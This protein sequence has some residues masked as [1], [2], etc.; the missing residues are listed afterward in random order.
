MET[1]QSIKTIVKAGSMSV[2]TKG[3]VKNSVLINPKLGIYQ[4]CTPTGELVTEGKN[5]KGKDKRPFFIFIQGKTLIQ[6][7]VGADFKDV[8]AFNNFTTLEN[9]EYYVENFSDLVKDCKIH[10]ELSYEPF[11]SGQENVKFND[12]GKLVDA[13]INS[14]IY[15]R[16]F[17]FNLKSYVPKSLETQAVDEKVTLPEPSEAIF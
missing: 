12:N 7:V 11:Y 1:T 5:E 14:Q 10:T 6:S 3:D 9:A 13:K 17:T 16:R 4:R 2:I 8:Q 15:Y